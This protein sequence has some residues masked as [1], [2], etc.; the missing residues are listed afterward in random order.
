MK[1]TKNLTAD[2]VRMIIQDEMGGFE[3]RISKQFENFRSEVMKSVD[4]IIGLFEKHDQEHEILAGR[5]KQIL[6]LEDKVEKLE[7][8][9]PQSQHAVA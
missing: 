9:H 3:E 2:D 4:K 1:Q 7:E 8:I 6:D 5:H